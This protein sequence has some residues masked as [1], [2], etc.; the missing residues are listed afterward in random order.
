MRS[1]HIVGAGPMYRRFPRPAKG[2]LVI[3]ADGGYRALTAYGLAADVVIG[4]FDSLGRAPDHP[5]VLTL[6]AEKDDTDMLAALRHG[7]RLDFDVFH[8][9]GATG[10]RPDHTQAN[11]QSLA[12]LAGC[13]A[14]GFLHG[15][16]QTV[17]CVRDGSLAFDGGC[18]GTLSVFAHSDV[19]EGVSLEG[20]KY[21]LQNAHLTSSFPLGVSNAFT[22]LPSRVTVLRGTLLIYYPEGSPTPT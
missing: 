11:L 16:T 14:R 1:C 20:L 4:D 8:L 12:F 7:L 17:T 15:R 5:H 2:D 9:Y 18:R 19:A 10:G 3:A 21:P 6:P 13:G 22:G